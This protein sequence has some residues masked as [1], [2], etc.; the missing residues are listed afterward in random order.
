MATEQG[1]RPT[2]SI[3]EVHRACGDLS[4]ATAEAIIATGASAADLDAALD[5]EDRSSE[6]GETEGGL[7]SAAAQVRQ[8]LD[9]DTALNQDPDP[10]AG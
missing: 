1:V 6:L 5:W 7:S 10:R 3:D 4:D 9:E 8:I 2:L